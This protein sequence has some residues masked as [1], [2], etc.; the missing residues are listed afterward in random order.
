[1]HAVG[2]MM[3]DVGAPHGWGPKRL[4]AQQL[5]LVLERL[6]S[7]AREGSADVTVLRQGTTEVPG[8]GVCC[9]GAEAG[10][11]R[12]RPPQASSGATTRQGG[13]LGEPLCVSELPPGCAVLLLCR[14]WCGGVSHR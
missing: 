11:G 7:A 5:Q 12:T 14:W 1:M 4:S 9:R 3:L 13:L 2:E 10:G 8:E 6:T